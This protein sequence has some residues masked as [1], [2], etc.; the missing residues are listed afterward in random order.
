MGLK[1]VKSKK[2]FIFS[3]LALFLSFLIFAFASYY[4]LEDDYQKDI[5]F[6]EARISYIN[7]EINYF[8]DIYI[9]DVFSYSLI[10]VLDSLSNYS[11]SQGNYDILN[12]NYTKLNNYIYEGLTNS[13]FD[14]IQINQLTNKSIYYFVNFFISDF[15]TNYKGDFKFNVLDINIY[16]TTPYYLN[17]QVHAQFNITLDDALSSWNFED[18]F[19]VEIP[20]FTLDDPEF[21]IQ[22][23]YSTKI[24]PLEKFATN[25][26][27]NLDNLNLTINNTY[28]I[29]HT[30]DKFKY[31]LGTSYLNRLLN[32]SSGS[33]YGVQGFYS[34]DYD[35]NY[36][37]VFDSSATNSIGKKFG[38]IILDIS[39]D[40][41]SSSDFTNYNHT[42]SFSSQ[43]DYFDNIN[44][45]LKPCMSNG[46]FN[47][48]LSENINLDKDNFN[49]NS[50][51]KFTLSIWVKSFSN[52]EQVLFDYGNT[53]EKVKLSLNSTG[54]ILFEIGSHNNGTNYIFTSNKAYNFSNWHLIVVSFDGDSGIGKIYVDGVISNLKGFFDDYEITSTKKNLLKSSTNIKLL[55]DIL[56]N[57]NFIGFIDEIAIYSQI[58]TDIQVTNLF[59]NKKTIDFDYID[60]IF[61]KSINFDGINDYIEINQSIFNSSL[62]QFSIETWINMDNYN[63]NTA[64]LNVPSNNIG[65]NNLLLTINFTNEN[66]SYL[67]FISTHLGSEVNLKSNYNFS[68]NKNYYIVFNFDG[69]NK[70]IYINSKLIASTTQNNNLDLSLFNLYL[71]TNNIGSNNLDN[72]FNGKID[73]IKIYNRYLTSDE[74]KYNYYNFQSNSKGCCNYVTLINPNKMGF[75]ST[76]YNKNISYN[77]KLFFDKYN[78]GID[79]NITLWEIKNITD[80]NTNNNYYNFIIDDCM[81]Q[82]LNV[83]SYN[84]TTNPNIIRTIGEYNN[85][86]DNLVR[87]GIY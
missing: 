81:L 49:L 19:N 30:R 65:G 5:I 54:N 73:E 9:K 26:N 64:I 86:C 43:P 21:L 41:N 57:N 25:L 34:F 74:I 17:L 16:E 50:T 69:L 24:R 22:A 29:V 67:E 35:Q 45:S 84:Y 12:K 39:F 63:N 82:T 56:D 71:G 53:S 75:N 61:D 83:Y 15:K 14:S 40:K 78:R 52:N 33:F 55:C 79:R 44:S 37:G 13:S 27:W 77:S 36:F 68:K 11:I 31:S 58:L 48:S 8:K 60:S 72:F 28:S 38:N 47:F 51:N 18:Y 76:T 46:C 6:K 59:D 7:S 87:A 80:S 1:M 62:S 23:N 42:S 70:D 10:N 2:G 20:I 3:F 66:S 4:L 85:S 32:I